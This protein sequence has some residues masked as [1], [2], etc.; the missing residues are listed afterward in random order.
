MARHV[1][2]RRVPRPPARSPLIAPH[3]AIDPAHF[4]TYS[5]FSLMVRFR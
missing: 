2:G 5:F 3:T 1:A 4:K